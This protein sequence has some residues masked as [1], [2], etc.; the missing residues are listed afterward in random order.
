[1]RVAARDTSS[2]TRMS[3]GGIEVCGSSPQN[4]R[5]LLGRVLSIDFPSRTTEPQWGRAAATTPAAAS[6][7]ARVRADDHGELVVGDLDGQIA[8]DGLLAVTQ[9]E[10]VGAESGG[11]RGHCSCLISRYRR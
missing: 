7:S 3:S 10:A 8:G 11:D 2:A 5:D 1:M 6:T 4:L 9:R